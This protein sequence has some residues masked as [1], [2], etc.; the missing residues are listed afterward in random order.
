MKVDL[1]L[2]TF[3]GVVLTLIVSIFSIWD[4]LKPKFPTFSVHYKNKKTIVIENYGKKLGKITEIKINGLPL[5]KFSPMSRIF[6]IRL[7]P[8]NI[9]ELPILQNDSIPTPQECSITYR[10]I[11]FKKTK[12]FSL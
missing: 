2:F 8:Q 1:E 4:R 9:I 11:L 6:P 3:I 7:E 5:D 12:I 10:M